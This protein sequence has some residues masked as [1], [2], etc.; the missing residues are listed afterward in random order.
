MSSCAELTLRVGTKIWTH[1]LC[2]LAARVPSP[3]TVS[4]G[5][6]AGQNTKCRELAGLNTC[7]TVFTDSAHTKFAIARCAH[8]IEAWYGLGAQTTS[9]KAGMCAKLVLKETLMFFFVSW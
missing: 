9:G 4:N 6:S 5:G 3:T 8:V 2:R 1:R 7:F